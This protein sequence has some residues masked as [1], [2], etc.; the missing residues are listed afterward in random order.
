MF[1]FTCSSMHDAG[2]SEWS[3]KDT[4]TSKSEG[5][6]HSLS[7]LCPKAEGP[8]LAAQKH[9]TKEKS[10]VELCALHD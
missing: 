5:F 8:G 4:A 1:D 3:Y 10:V 2:S 7:R 9:S 6:P